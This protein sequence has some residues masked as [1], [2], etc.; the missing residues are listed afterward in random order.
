MY[1]RSIILELLISP[2]MWLHVRHGPFQSDMSKL[3]NACLLWKSADEKIFRKRRKGGGETA[4]IE[5]NMVSAK[6]HA[7]CLLL[8]ASLSVMC[9]CQ[10]KYKYPTPQKCDVH[11]TVITKGIIQESKKY[12]FST[13]FLGFLWP[14]YSTVEIYSIERGRSENKG[15]PP[16][17]TGFRPV[18][19][20]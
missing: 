18:S 20:S 16:I 5:Y 1:S 17:Q 11:C 14:F 3:H 13:I 12:I 4:R 7:F 2:C 10:S 15:C 19:F 8:C 9:R 6:S